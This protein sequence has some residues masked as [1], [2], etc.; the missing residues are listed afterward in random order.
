[1][2]VFSFQKLSSV[3]KIKILSCT[4]L[5]LILEKLECGPMPNVMTAQ[6][7]IG[8]A[9]CESSAISFVVQRRKVWL[10]SAA[11][12]PYSNAA[13]IRE[14]KTWTQSEFCTCQNSVRGAK[15]PKCIYNV[16]AQETAKDRAKFGWPPLSDVAAVRKPRR[17]IG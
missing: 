11:G 3:L 6:P 2:K 7:N 14:R 17:E 10:R 1:V 15:A 4:A 16:P 8:G 13:N 12:V 9:L 5:I